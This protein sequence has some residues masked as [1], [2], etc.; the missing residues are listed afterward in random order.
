MLS[1]MIL[2]LPLIIFR[3]FIFGQKTL[4]IDGSLVLI[5]LT[6]IFATIPGFEIEASWQHLPIYLA[7]GVIVF[8]LSVRATTSHPV[9]YLRQILRSIQYRGRNIQK[10][11]AWSAVMTAFSEEILWRVVFQTILSVTVGTPVSVAVVAASFSL[12]H[13]RSTSGFITIQF[14]ELL[15][16]ALILGVLFALTHDVLL[17]I[18]VHA[19]RNYLI[20]IRGAVNETR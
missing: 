15:A 4:W 1:N 13:R 3:S 14:F 18:A 5:G 10:R 6:C 11:V 9:Q 7:L 20:G 8:A 2:W 12:L 19:I 16:F 17:V